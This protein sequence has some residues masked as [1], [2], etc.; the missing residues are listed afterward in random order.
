MPEALYLTDSA[1]A[2]RLIASE[3]LA[4]LIGFAIDQQVTVQQAFSGPLRP[5][6]DWTQASSRLRL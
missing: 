3:P 1:E 5:F 6:L 2:N 4:L